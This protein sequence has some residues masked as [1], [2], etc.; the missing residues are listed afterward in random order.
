MNN[1]L[2]AKGEILSEVTNRTTCNHCDISLTNDHSGPCP[3]CGKVGK[4]LSVIGSGS[5]VGGG[6]SAIRISEVN[7]FSITH[8]TGANSLARTV[9]E[10]E[11]SGLTI[12]KIN[13]G[14]YQ[15]YSSTVVI[16]CSAFL[17]AY[18]NEFYS[19]C[20]ERPSNIKGLPIDII[21]LYGRLWNK[22]IPRTAKYSI[23]EKY[24]LALEI[25][26]VEQL[27]KGDSAYQ[28]VSLLIQLRNSFVHYEPEEVLAFSSL[29][30][31]ST[32]IHKLE[33]KLKGHFPESP[34]WPK[35]NAFYPT[36]MLGFGCCT[37][38]VN[39]T[40]DFYELFNCK[41]GITALNLHH[42]KL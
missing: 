12:D 24:E 20:A 41:M 14:E 28:E 39:C 27:N 40:I 42:L 22:N 31:I 35:G 33:K 16:L 6:P 23:L 37:W 30:T 21:A 38:A 25:A 36:R 19:N 11:L 10:I 17:E 1:E 26:N 5:A 7:Y 29:P 32:E 9:K 13:I 3:S 34:L 2:V 8:L 18:I 4:G 15:S